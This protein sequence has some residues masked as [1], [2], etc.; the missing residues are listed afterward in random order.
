MK[1]K[2]GEWEGDEG[3][4]RE[5]VGKEGGGVGKDGEEYVRIR[6]YRRASGR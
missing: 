4:E 2:G 5:E 6:K 3:E 1:E